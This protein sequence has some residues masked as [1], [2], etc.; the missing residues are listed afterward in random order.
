MVSHIE[1]NFDAFCKLL[2]TLPAEAMGKFALMRDTKVIDF[3]DSAGDARKAG[4]LAYAD[5]LFSIQHVIKAPV[6]LGFYS[7]AHPHH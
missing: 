5:G 7:H 1:H 4:R 2:P 3:F 6:D